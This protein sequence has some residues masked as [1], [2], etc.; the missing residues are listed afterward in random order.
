[1]TISTMPTVHNLKNYNPKG[2]YNIYEQQYFKLKYR[3]AV[4]LC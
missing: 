2:A 1:M 4:T 3:F